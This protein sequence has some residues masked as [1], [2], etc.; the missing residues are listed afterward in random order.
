M[1]KFINKKEQVYDLKLTSYGHYLMSVGVFKPMYYAF[2]D[3]NVL[4]DGAYAF[5]SESQN[6]I[7]K[8]IK[9]E[10]SYLESLVLFRD[11]ETSQSRSLGGPLVF[12]EIISNL[13]PQ[14]SIPEPDIYRYD[15]A[16]GDAWLDGERNMAPAWKIVSLNN[17]ITSST[18]H[19][20]EKSSSIPQIN[21]IAKYR[22]RARDRD[23]NF[24]P[25]TVNEI[26]NVT[27]LFVD[28]Q[29]ITLTLDD[30]LVYAEEVNTETLTKNFDVEVFYVPTGSD[31]SLVRKYF[32]NFSNQ[33]V[34]GF[35]V[36]ETI[37]TT[38]GDP[39][40]NSG[41]VEYYLDVVTDV[42]INRTAA[43]RGAAQFN[44]QSYYVD[45]DFDCTEEAEREI[46]FDIYGAVTEPEICQD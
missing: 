29:T 3:D 21:I 24:N 37:D 40:E 43:C 4:Y 15:A 30:V 13:T 8:R 36:S 31:T 42:N 39:S 20:V 10:T 28:N 26:E 45:L 9:E 34:D 25:E 38:I 44:K 27:P 17:H 33:I 18:T 16:I 2:Y 46:Y 5:I 23:F 19:Y 12:S 32:Q 22:L 41:S 11:V 6:N 7:H 35:L 14:I 1:A